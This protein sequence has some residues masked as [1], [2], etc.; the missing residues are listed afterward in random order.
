[1]RLGVN[2]FPRRPTR[3]VHGGRISN[4]RILSYRDGKVTFRYKDYA[5]E[6]QRTMTVPATELLFAASCCTFCPTAS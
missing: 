3:P 1:M 6:S 2:A 5:H 4:S